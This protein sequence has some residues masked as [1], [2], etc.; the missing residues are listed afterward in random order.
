MR[1]DARRTNASDSL[2]ARGFT[3]VKL[4]VT[5]SIVA[6]LAGLAMPS[7]SNLVASQR[8]RSAGTDLHTAL[9]KAR[10]EALKRNASV[11]LE[12]KEENNWTRGWRIVEVSAPTTILEDHN[13]F[14][15]ITMTGPAD[16]V[17]AS[18]GRIRGT[19]MPSFQLSGSAT[20]AVSCISV[21]LSGMPAQ[22]SSSC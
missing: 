14:Q 2:P 12:P 17:Y 21:N 11:R 10:S 1:A 22:R 5:I 19:S 20:A 4:L 6:V 3:L 9:T 7:F 16:V 18:S 8:V 13:G 15:G